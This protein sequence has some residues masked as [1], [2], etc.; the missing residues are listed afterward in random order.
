MLHCHPHAYPTPPS[1]D[2]PAKC[3]FEILGRSGRV[4]CPKNDTH[5]LTVYKRGYTDQSTRA[6]ENHGESTMTDDVRSSVLVIADHL[7]HHCSAVERL[8]QRRITDDNDGRSV[9]HLRSAHPQPATRDTNLTNFPF[10]NNHSSTRLDQLL[11]AW[12]PAQ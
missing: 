3:F 4:S 9:V 11:T 2:S 7:H 6:S 1:L 5:N 10:T 12:R 8:A